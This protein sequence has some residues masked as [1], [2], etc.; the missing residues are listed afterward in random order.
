MNNFVK[1]LRGS[2][3]KKETEGS[4]IWQFLNLLKQEE[5]YLKEIRP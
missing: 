3:Q 1:E 2:T 4:C 5:T